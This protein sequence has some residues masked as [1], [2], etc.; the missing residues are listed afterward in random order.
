MG[1]LTIL[2]AAQHMRNR[3]NLTDVCQKL[4]AKSFALG[5]APDKPGDV[6]KFQLCRDHI[7]RFGQLCKRIKTRVGHRNTP[8]IWLDGTERIV[9]GIGG[10]GLRQ[11]VEQGR[12][13]NIW[14][15]DNTAV[16]SHLD[17]PLS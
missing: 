11:R 4:V 12:F 14:Q 15:T 2:E 3:V 17:Y 10:G 7:C 6:D 5:G 16:K 13:A 1:N 8:C 9:R